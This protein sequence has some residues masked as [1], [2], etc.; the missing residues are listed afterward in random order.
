[1]DLFS[2]SEH[3]GNIDSAHPR[4]IAFYPSHRN[5][6]GHNST[7]NMAKFLTSFL[8]SG[9]LVNLTTAFGLEEEIPR[10]LSVETLFGESVSS[11][12]GQFQVRG[13]DA[14]LRASVALLAEQ[15]RTE[16]HQLI[17]ESRADFKIPVH[18]LLVAQP[19]NPS[20]R[21]N[22]TKTITFHDGGYQFRLIINTA[23]GLDVERFQSAITSALVY[24]C[25]LENRSTED[26]E[27]PLLVQPWL[28]EGLRE[29]N[30]WQ[31]DISDRRLYEALFQSGG[32]FNLDDLFTMTEVKHAALDAASR[33]AFTISSGAIVMALLEQ[34]GGKEAFRKFLAEVALFA[35]ETPTLLRRHFPELNLSENSMEKW[36]R[37]LL[38]HKGTASLTESLSI[39]KTEAALNDLLRIH[40]R[41][42]D[43]GMLESSI[44]AWPDLLNLESAERIPATRMAADALVRLSYRC[45]PSYRPILASYQ[46]ALISI[47]HE[48]VNRESLATHFD[49][50]ALTRQNM[51][52]KAERARDYM[53]WFEITR[54]RETSGAFVDYLRIKQQL[55][56]KQYNTRN[57]RVSV[58]LDRFDAIFHRE[59]DPRTN[60]HQRE[61][62]IQ[63]NLPQR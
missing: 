15:I 48:N 4:D 1:M 11:N 35:G 52:A 38:A 20:G 5:H 27:T 61:W 57:D 23:R 58:T 47:T 13:G 49:E 10:A 18:I 2:D 3:A 31:Q 51:I 22:T 19:A 36:W 46:K 62:Q 14:A 24:T 55:A 39:F 44:D 30:R 32:L 6:P 56:E 45:F 41:D 17:E 29:A 21:I 53:D 60:P 28:V 16:F 63:S 42:E 12:S 9:L 54:A 25:S 34:P 37:L 59:S 50:L 7:R 26:A 40:L 43:G 8:F 33:A